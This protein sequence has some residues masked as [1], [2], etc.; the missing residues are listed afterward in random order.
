MA[1][2]DVFNGDADGICALQ[3]LRLALP[4]DSELVTGVKRDIALLSRVH[5][6]A[7]DEVT[8]LDISLADNR[9]ALLRLL[10]AGARCVYFDHHFAGDIPAHPSLDAH[11][12]TEPGVC[13]SLLGD[14]YLGGR[15]RAWAVVAAFGDNLP[16][17][18]QR[19]AE[20]LGKTADEV[21]T[22]RELGECLN[23]NAYGDEPQD[24]FFF[25]AKLYRRL[26]PYADP[27]QFAAQDAAFQRLRAGL[28]EDL[29]HA[30]TIDP[31]LDTPTHY[32]VVMPDLPW[33]RRVHGPWANRLAVEQPQRAHA[34]LIEHGVSYRVSVRAPLLRPAGADEL[35]RKFATGG[36]RSGAGGINRLP[37]ERLNEFVAAF[38]ASF[39]P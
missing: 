25:P 4:R 1:F 14:E 32:V 34:V 13:T 38:R 37:R 8:V 26:Q 35:C 18:A 17:E 30:A 2:Y 21:A 6:G 15:F 36:G 33:G 28:S 10:A 20:S 19:A 3:Q 27:L 12:R 7:G 24:L 31:L 29:E 9:D 23:Y 5:A 16:Q 11:I 39:P 22:L